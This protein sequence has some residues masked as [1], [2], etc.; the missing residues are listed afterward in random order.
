MAHR[1]IIRQPD[2]KLALWSSQIDDF[3][4]IDATKDEIVDYFVELKR[5][6][7][8]YEISAV[9]T[10]IEAGRKAYGNFTLTWDDCLVDYEEA[11]GRR[12]SLEQLRAETREVSD[13]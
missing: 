8:E 1:Q 5:Q 6:E 3:L 4:I 11:H 2:G 9:I 10:H 13:E 12:T 7:V